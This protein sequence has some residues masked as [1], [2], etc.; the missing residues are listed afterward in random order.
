MV[1]PLDSMRQGLTKAYLQIEQPRLPDS[2]ALIP[3]HFNPTEYQ[4]QKQN[5]F[6]DINIP[7]LETPPIQFVRGSGEKLTTELLVDTS[8]TLQDVREK[9]VYKLRGLMNIQ[10]DLHA[11]PIVRLVWDKDVFRGVLESLNVTYLMFRP[12]GIPL[13]AKLAIALKEYRTVEEQIKE[14]PR[15]SPD[16][17]KIYTVVRGDTISSVAF[18]LFRDGSMWRA[19][20]SANQIRDPRRLSPGMVLTIPKIN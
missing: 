19:I 15:N 18:K 14:R 13:R 7:G 6:A 1:T 4:L 9:Y 12:D 20:A 8:D 11:P 16:V 3:V 10:G 5:S 2:Q 17:Q